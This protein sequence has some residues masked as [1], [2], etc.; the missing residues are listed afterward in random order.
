MQKGRSTN[1]SSLFLRVRNSCG[2][3]PPPCV[4]ILFEVKILR[5]TA[6]NKPLERYFGGSSP[7]QLQYQVTE[8]AIN[9]VGQNIFQSLDIA[10][11]NSKHG[12]LY[13]FLSH[14]SLK[15]FR[16]VNKELADVNV[17]LNSDKRESRLH[18]ASEM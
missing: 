3:R 17:P 13:Y 14:L 15:L 8:P 7:F 10:Q 4:H 5:S 1:T 11:H 16:N 2:N 6:E 12:Q 9:Y 18:V